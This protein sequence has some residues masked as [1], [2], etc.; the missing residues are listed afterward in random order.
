MTHSGADPGKALRDRA[1]MQRAR[2]TVTELCSEFHAPVGLHHGA[3]VRHISPHTGEWCAGRGRM[4]LSGRAVA[5]IEGDD[6]VSA[7]RRGEW[8]RRVI[9]PRA[10][11]LVTAVRE[12]HRLALGDRRAGL[13]RAELESV[14]VVLAAMV[15][16]D[17][18]AAE[19]L[20]WI[21][22]NDNGAPL[23]GVA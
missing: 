9:L 4:D 12:E 14:V 20:A 16:D 2:G 7:R 23:A 15:P 13:G 18:P 19:L 3:V 21:T 5:P 8:A 17:Q 6:E 1:L 11:E 10:L 22:W